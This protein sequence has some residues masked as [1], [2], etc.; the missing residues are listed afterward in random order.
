VRF[1]ADE[2]AVDKVSFFRVLQISPANH[3]STIPPYTYHRSTGCEITLTR[4]SIIIP[5]VLIYRG[6][7]MMEAKSIFETSVNFYQTIR[8]NIPE[9]SHLDVLKDLLI[10]IGTLGHC[11]FCR[12]LIFCMINSFIKKR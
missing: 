7:L 8:P 10:L 6:G 1:V 11:M 9:D 4:Q 12:L 3:H 5:P 2:V